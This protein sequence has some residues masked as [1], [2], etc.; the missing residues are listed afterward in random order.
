MIIN[1]PL[2]QR[3]PVFYINLPLL[4]TREAC[5]DVGET[6]AYNDILGTEGGFM[7]YGPAGNAFL[8]KPSLAAKLIEA[9]APKKPR[10]IFMA[11]DHK[12]WSFWPHT[13]LETTLCI[14]S[15]TAHGANVW[16]RN[17]RIRRL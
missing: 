10:V 6:L 3:R 8:C 15:S 11:A 17:V 12:P 13:S 9:V 14:A 5:V 16:Y 2:Q 4:H 7:H 1:R